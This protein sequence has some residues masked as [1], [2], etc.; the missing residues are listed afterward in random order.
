MADPTAALDQKTIRTSPLLRV[1]GTLFAL[2]LGA[3]G[4]QG[5]SD[6]AD[7][8]P[9]PAASDFQER[10]ATP[11]TD[12]LA[13]IDRQPDPRAPRLEAA[14]KD[15]ADLERASEQAEESWQRWL[16]TR[17]T[18]GGTKHEDQAI[19]SRRDQLDQLRAERD[20][21]RLQVAAL[22]AQPDPR[23]QARAAVNERLQ[24][25]R[26]QAARE[27]A[28]ADQAWRLRVLAARIAL[29]LPV[30]ALAVVLWRRRSRLAY[31][32]LLWAYWAFT[33]WMVL[34]GMAP[35]LPRYGGYAPLTLGAGVTVW[36]AIS[37]ARWMNSRAPLRRRRIVDQAIARHRCPACDRDY[38]LGRETALDAGLARKARTLHYD[39][40]A[41]HPAH[42][43]ACGL[44]LFAPC[45]GCQSLRMVQ[46]E[47]C[48]TCGEPA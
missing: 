25:A 17:A 42:C 21:A 29:V 22:L 23:D 39:L 33:A 7:L 30:L 44:A 16:A 34:W 14:R 38:L 32:T 40:A 24:A 48:S 20:D 46:A 3:L 15:A 35:Y 19:R 6:V 41:L 28:A 5:L 4:T 9:A 2:F 11:L 12:E 26:Q 8:F 1:L 37:L 13:A 36:G 31:V 27:Y 43:G 18:L 45:G 10:L 47:R